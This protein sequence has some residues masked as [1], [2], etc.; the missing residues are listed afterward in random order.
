MTPPTPSNTQNLTTNDALAYLKAVKDAFQDKK[1][2]YE[3]FLEVMKGFKSHRIDT[4]GV[5]LRVKELFIGHRDL[6]LGFN[7]FLPNGYQIKLLEEN[8][9]VQFEEAISFV[10]KMKSR[11]KNKEN[12]YKA[13]IDILNMYQWENKSITDVYQEVAVLFQ[14]HHDLL[15]EF[16]KFLPNS[17]KERTHSLR[18][19]CDCS[20]DSPNLDHEQRHTEQENDRKQERDS[21]KRDRDEKNFELDSCE[22]E[23]VRKRKSSRRVDGSELVHQGVEVAENLGMYNMSASFGDKNSLKKRDSR[24]RDRDEKDF[25]HDS[26]EL[27]LARKRKSSRHVDGPELVHQGGEVA[28]N[29]GMYNMFASFGDK[30]SL[31]SIYAEEFTFCEKVKE[32][33]HPDA[34]QEFL[35]CLHIYRKEIITRTELMNLV[36]DILGKHSDIMDNFNEFL[37]H[38]ENMGHVVSS[39]EIINPSYRMLSPNHPMPATTHRTKLGNSVLNDTWVSVASDTE[40][41][42]FKNMPKNP[43][44]ESLFKCEDDRF[45]LDMLIE[46]AKSTTKRVEELLEKMQNNT[47]NLESPFHIEDYFTVLHLRCIERLYGDHGLDVIDVLRKN[48]T[49]AL[50]IILTRLKQ[51]QEEWSKCRADFNKVWAEI[52]SE[53]HQKSLDNCSFSFKQHDTENLNAKVSL[54]SAA[55]QRTKIK[56]ISEKKKEDDVILAIAA[57]IG[58]LESNGTSDVVGVMENSNSA[59][60]DGDIV[61]ELATSKIRAANVNVVVLGND[62]HDNY[63]LSLTY[64]KA[65]KDAF[66]DKKEKYDEFLEVMQDFKRQRID[67]SGVILRVKEL[68]KGHR[69]LLLGFYTFFPNGYHIKL[70]EENKPV[71]F[72]EAISFVNKMKDQ[73]QNDENVYKAFIDILNMYRRDN[74]SIKDFYQ[75]VA[76]LFQSHH[77]LLEEF[78]HFLPNTSGTTA[79]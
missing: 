15:E 54:I 42:S 45:E 47:F 75:D 44:E 49:N 29:F 2:K 27:E 38:C 58:D 53:N 10:N 30:N 76:V 65:V 8:K 66:Q 16:T 59:K 57:G 21:R 52:Y 61:Q 4:S 68:F 17:S 46:S 56:E 79:P 60:I 26:C 3:E 37:A 23:L 40:D 41:Y 12:V 28:E 5:I 35:K 39:R 72:E 31:K 78:T 50:L 20:I 33:L 18:L 51:K 19:E 62:I 32:K 22:L 7:T 63:V 55:T 36:I 14:S 74:K 11:F 24:K 9:P 77:D 69:D 67:T 13:V 73:F 70:P 34:Y 48:A 71:E 64:L 25:E 43:Y 1:E 6:L